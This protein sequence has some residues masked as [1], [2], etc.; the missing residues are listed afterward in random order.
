MERLARRRPRRRPR[1]AAWAGWGTLVPLVVLV[2]LWVAFGNLDRD[3]GYAAA[4][5]VLAVVFSRAA[6][7]SPAAR[8]RR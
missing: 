5:L 4:A 2:S 6:K 3:L 7:R 1:A 8:S